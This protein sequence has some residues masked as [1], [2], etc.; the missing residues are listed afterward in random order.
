MSENLRLF[1]RIR[2]C[3][4]YYEIL[5]VKKDATE[6]QLKKEYRKLALQLHPDKCRVPHST[7]A[8]K[9]QFSVS[10]SLQPIA[11]RRWLN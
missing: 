5:N 2:H 3:K 9:G 6:A 1:F 8:F 4:D 11:I 7:E 10:F